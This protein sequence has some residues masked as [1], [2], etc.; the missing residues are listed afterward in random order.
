MKREGRS[1]LIADNDSEI[2]IF[3]ESTYLI[4]VQ[5]PYSKCRLFLYAIAIT[6]G[7]FQYGYSLGVYSPVS[8]V[9]M[10]LF[11]E[12]G[13]PWSIAHKEPY[14]T[15]ISTIPQ[16]GGFIGAF[17]AFA[18]I[19]TNRLRGIFIFN[20]LSIGGALLSCFLNM[21]ALLCGRFINGYA[22]G[23]FSFLIPLYVN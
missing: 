18:F 16:V 6:L 19:K 22:A 21:P 4:N 2:Q 5:A 10:Q 15:I 9:L 23:A 12:Q 8:K 1:A 14:N 11:H 20:L 13:F 3:G 7:S 17:T